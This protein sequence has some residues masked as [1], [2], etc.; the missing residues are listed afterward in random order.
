MDL[1]IYLA[2][3]ATNRQTVLFYRS[4]VEKIY[5]ISNSFV[6]LINTILKVRSH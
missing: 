2:P 4:E 1:V 6:E 5:R 3:L